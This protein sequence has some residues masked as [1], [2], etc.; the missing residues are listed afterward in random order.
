[1]IKN[2]NVKEMMCGN[3]RDI[4]RNLR[5]VVARRESVVAC[6]ALV[7]AII[8]PL[9]HAQTVSEAEA[10]RRA[11]HLVAQMTTAEKIAQLHGFSDAKTNRI[12]PGV[13]RLGIPAFPITNG[14]AGVGPGGAGVQ[15]KATALPAPI[16]LAATWDPEAARAYGKLAGAETRL[17]GS[18]LLEAPD[19][20]IVRIPQGGRTFETYGE[21]PWLT[22][23]LTVANIEGVQSAGVMA[24]VKHYL[25]NNQETQRGSINEIIDD[26]TLHEIYMPGFKAA[27]QEAHV[28]SIMCAYPRVNGAFNCENEPIAQRGPS[29]RVGIQG[30]CHVRLRSNPQYARQHV[31]RPRSGIAGRALLCIASATGHRQWHGTHESCRSSFSSASY[32]TMIE[33]GLF[34]RKQLDRVQNDAILLLPTALFP[35]PHR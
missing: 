20:N 10:L 30:V 27:V 16:A 19:I 1:M 31:G 4:M 28:D 17:L 29:R 33:A 26:R 18:D 5:R 13:P 12:V 21:D 23:R 7:V 34:D 15:L 3:N 2:E 6:L 14:P 11:K 8:A 35:T 25:A 32:A 22:S 9:C 24:N